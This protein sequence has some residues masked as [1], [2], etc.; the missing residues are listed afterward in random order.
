MFKYCQDF[1]GVTLSLTSGEKAYTYDVLKFDSVAYKKVSVNGFNQEKK[2]KEVFSFPHVFDISTLI[3][4]NCVIDMC[5]LEGNFG[6]IEIRKCSISGSLTEKLFAD[7]LSVSLCGG[8]NIKLS[9]LADSRVQ[10]LDIFFC[11]FNLCIDLHGAKNLYGRLGTLQ[12]SSDSDVDLSDLEGYWD[13]VNFCACKFRNKVQQNTFGGNKLKIERCKTQG[14]IDLFQEFNGNNVELTYHANDENQVFQLS[15]YNQSFKFAQNVS[16]TLSNFQIDLSQVTGT[17]KQLQLNYCSIVGT[18]CKQLVVDK[19]NLYYCTISTA[20]VGQF[21]CRYLMFDD[22]YRDSLEDLPQQLQK[23]FIYGPQLN[24]RSKRYPRLTEIEIFDSPI[25]SLSLFNVPNI[26]KLELNECKATKSTALIQK[27]IKQKKQNSANLV[28]LKKQH[29]LIKVQNQE[30]KRT[31]EAMK[32]D[33][34]DLIY[35][36]IN[37]ITIGRE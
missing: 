25:G 4:Q 20:Q 27:V 5:Q 14:F 33:L 19:L 15:D 37:L 2:C 1:E 6:E 36:D 31:C 12:F 9:Q 8:Q 29:L 34:A 26:Q 11:S 28:E 22:Y 24:L 32:T 10:K 23:L 16:L 21:A 35:Y 30:Q 7:R 3:L 17:F 13:L 18:V